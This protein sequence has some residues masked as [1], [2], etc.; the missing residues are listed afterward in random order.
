[1]NGPQGEGVAIHTNLEPRVVAQ[2]GGSEAPVGVHVGRAP[3]DS[4]PAHGGYLGLRASWPEVPTKPRACV[5]RRPRHQRGARPAPRC[6]AG[7]RARRAGRSGSYCG[8]P[9][10]RRPPGFVTTRLEDGAALAGRSGGGAHPPGSTERGTGS[11][12]TVVPGLGRLAG[13]G[14]PPA[15]PG[16]SRAACRPDAG[17]AGTRDAGA[18]VGAPAR[19]SAPGRLPISVENAALAVADGPRWGSAGL[20]RAL[21]EPANRNMV[22]SGEREGTPVAVSCPRWATLDA[23]A[24][25][26]FFV[27]RPASGSSVASGGTRTTTSSSR[28]ISNSETQ[29]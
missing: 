5:R 29:R 24:S 20:E 22:G 3:F 10:T 9:G 15:A 2:E 14:R 25:S 11:I 1:M 19:P 13:P 16:G 7:R 8:A 6:A 28:S 23:A 26:A 12:V 17:R 21:D 4:S 18:V 27:T